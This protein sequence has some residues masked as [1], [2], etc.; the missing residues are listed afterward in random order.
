M[1]TP[2]WP[3]PDYSLQDLSAVYRWHRHREA[4]GC[5]ASEAFK[6]NRRSAPTGAN[7]NVRGRA[8]H[9]LSHP[10]V[11]VPCTTYISSG[12]ALLPSCWMWNPWPRF[13]ASLSPSLP[14]SLPRTP[15]LTAILTV[16]ALQ[17]CQGGKGLLH[18]MPELGFPAWFRWAAF[19]SPGGSHAVSWSIPAQGRA[20]KQLSLRCRGRGSCHYTKSP[21]FST[22]TCSAAL[23]G[24]A[25]S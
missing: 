5:N 13:S 3:K 25:V 12:K 1:E 9:C 22:S 6:T 10:D 15:L 17:G 2:E 14:F 18:R 23:T 4:G 16:L 7:T 21:P 11:R 24:V 19:W 8:R 20:P